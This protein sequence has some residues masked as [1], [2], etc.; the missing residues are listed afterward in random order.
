MISNCT[1]SVS[2]SSPVT[3]YDST[4][5]RNLYWSCAIISPLVTDNSELSL[6]TSARGWGRG[7]GL[8]LSSTM[9]YPV[10]AIAV[11]WGTP[12]FVNTNYARSYLVKLEAEIMH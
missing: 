11:A 9:A 10:R 8:L 7:G 12:A 2:H 4:E 5:M 6:A 1:Q 3:G